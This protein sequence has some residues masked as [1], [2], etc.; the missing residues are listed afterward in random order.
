MHKL[1]NLLILF[2]LIFSCN[3]YTVDVNEVSEFKNEKKVTIL[4]YNSDAMEPFISKNDNY[5]FFN[6]LE[7]DSSKDLYYAEKINDTT[8]YFKGKIEGVNT[9]YVDA[10]PTMDTANNFYFISTRDLDSSNKTLF[11]GNFNNGEV[12]ELSK[13]EGTINIETPYW[14]NMG[15]EISKDGSLLLV[16]NAKFNIGDNFP[17]EGNIRFAV[18]EG[19]YFNI[20]DNE[21]DILQN[22]NTT[23]AIEYAGEISADMLELF[24]S[25]VTLSDPPVFKLFYAKRDNKFSVFN[26]PIQITEPFNDNINAF[27]EA[28]TISN[29][30]KRLY[31]HKL[32]EDGIFS[33]Y[34]L[35]RN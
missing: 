24:Y 6:N 4:N 31:Y 30:G 17:N 5:L 3:K 11:Y 7:G 19:N 23:N 2:T 10:N 16:S 27:V 33:I 32:N 26:K 12:T 29:D 28:P 18:K 34:M 25:Q 20:P 8:F 21:E 35:S 14:I 15:V 22:I 1:I 13:I 9:T